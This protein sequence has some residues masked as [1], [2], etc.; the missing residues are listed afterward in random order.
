M[1]DGQGYFAADAD[2]AEEAGRLRMIEQGSDPGTFRCL[3]R[4]GV[5]PDWSC[6]EVG[7]GA[8]S[9]AAWLGDRVGPDGRVVALDIDT[10]H[11]SWITA[12]NI[13][14]R[15]HNIETD[16]LETDRYDL[17]HC[18]ALLEHLHNLERAVNQMSC[19]LRAGGWLLVEGADFARYRSVDKQ[20]PLAAG[21]DAVMTQTFA[22]VK[23]KGIFDPFIGPT[24]PV[25]LAGAPLQQI[26]VEFLDLTV[27]G[28]DPMALMFETSW[29]RLDGLLATAGV[30][31]GRQ[32]A[33]RHEAHHDPSFSF[34][35][36]SAAAWGRRA[37]QSG[38]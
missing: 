3:Q 38:S 15:V 12:P 8:G 34:N 31:T 2:F 19:A 33:V 20:H 32:A 17:V 36:G 26:D 9:V 27:H 11:L 7:A 18:R 37:G 21:F 4:L 35:Y 30:I 25:L 13:T 22:F 24:F 29:Q 1:S 23:N 16:D 10:R 14:V 28:G 6:L 5:G